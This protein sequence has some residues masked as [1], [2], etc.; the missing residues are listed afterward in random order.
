MKRLY[1]CTMMLAAFISAS[2]QTTHDWE[3]PSVLSINKLPYH[4]TLQLPS[5]WKECKE[6]VSLDGQWQFHWSRNPEERPAD[7]YREDYDV[8]KWDKITVPGNWQT[9]GYGTPIYTNIEYPFVRNR[10]SVTTEPPSDWTAYENRNPVGSYVTFIDVSEEMLKQNLILHFGGVHSAFYVWING[11]KVGYSQ[12]SM[13]PAEF[14]V[15]KYIRAGKNRLAV[16]V[17][18]WSDG[19]YLEDQDMWRL[20]GIYRPVQL[21]VRPLVHISDYHVTAEP[22][23]D[24]SQAEIK[25]V[26]SICNTSKKAATVH[27]VMTIEGIAADMG[28]LQINACD[29]ADYTFHYTL[30]NPRLWSAEKPNLYPF[31]IELKDTKGNTIEHFDYHFG[32]KKVEVIGE[33]FKIN[34]K[35]VKLRGVNRHDHHP[36]TGRYVDDATYEEDIRLMKQANI[37]FLRTSHYPDREYLYELCDRW[38]IYVMDEANHETHGYGYANSEM[39]EDLAWQNAHWIALNRW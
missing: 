11:Q 35:N 25:A 9:Q 34:G 32:V 5:K 15:T 6:I 8:S 23:A 24:Y 28:K 2:A 7:F 10:P 39:G 37:N 26:V 27:P 18:R 36:K 29:T 21:W 14:D 17:Y 22:N 30:E 12:N 20:S 31:S 3:N 33:V 1:L 38:G 19:S 16:E 13:T 4:V